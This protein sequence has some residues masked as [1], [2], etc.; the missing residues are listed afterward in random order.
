MIHFLRLVRP[1]NLLI[2][3]LTMYSVRFFYV[4]LS[5]YKVH[6]SFA[7]LHEQIDFFLL[8]ISTVMIGAAGNIINDYFDV[9]A[10]RVN[11]PERLII[12]RHI[13]QRWAIMSHW[14]LNGLAFSIAI[15]LSIR[16]H[17][18]WYVFVHLISINT[19]WFY[20][21]YFKRKALIGNVLIAMLTA[22]V[23]ILC[24]IHFY[25]VGSLS[26][27]RLEESGNLLTHYPAW[28][29]FLAEHGR[30]V[31]GMAF[32]AFILNLSREIIK[33]MQDIKGD[34]MIHAKTLPMMIGI[35]K[36]CAIAALFLL[37]LPVTA[38]MMYFFNVS[39]IFNDLLFFIPFVL[40]IVLS[41]FVALVMLI[42]HT[43]KSLKFYDSVLKIAML[44][45][46][47]LPYYWIILL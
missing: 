37:G 3:A 30:F 25:L 22:L 31:F 33:D 6:D 11:R 9:K 5:N 23:P 21:M 45:G 8:V 47:I 13:K 17:T 12:S 41:S 4:G 27:L 10:D 39:F 28:V 15:Y 43:R 40:S 42:S 38:A 1:L 18:F 7:G 46:L 20:S 35:R 16:Y 19:L 34:E 36:S 24:G 26:D 14:M 2:I 29:Y 44:L 32:F